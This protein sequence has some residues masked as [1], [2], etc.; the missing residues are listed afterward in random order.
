MNNIRVGHTLGTRHGFLTT[1]DYAQKIGANFFQ[2][3][4][5]S[6]HQ[7]NGKRRTEDELIELKRKLVEANIGIVVHANY[8]LNYCNPTNSYKH[9]QAIKLLV[10]DLKESVK[11]GAV[12]VVIHMGKKLDMDE[13][14]AINNYVSGVRSALK[15]TSKGEYKS[16]VVILETGAGQGSEVCTN[17]FDLSK[18]Y[19]TFTKKERERIKI[20]LDTCHIFAAGE[21]IGHEDYVDIYCGLVDTLLG[22]DNIAVIHLND[23]KCVANS[24]KDRHADLGKGHIKIDGLKKFTQTCF[25]KGVP[26]VLETPCDKI[27]KDKQIQMVKD[28]MN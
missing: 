1:V 20:C 6:P 11:I 25:T 2:I 4:L 28:W 18:L 10:A 26:V 5:S 19:R 16:S 13:D 12:G 17:I 15:Q 8:M 3:F 7:Y 23:S 9:T 22:W 14:V 27:K 24:C 21:D